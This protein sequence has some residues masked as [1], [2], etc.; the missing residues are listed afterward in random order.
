MDQVGEWMNGAR[1]PRVPHRITLARALE[2]D[3]HWLATGQDVP[4]V[5]TRPTSSLADRGREAVD[6]ARGLAELR[7]QLVAMA[8]RAEGVA[9]G[10]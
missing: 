8:E 3:V 5:G 9:R 4:A 6:V 7:P 1:W 10:R 2:V